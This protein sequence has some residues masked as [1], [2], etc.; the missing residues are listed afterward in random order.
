MA[1]KRG[2]SG[3]PGN[4]NGAHHP[5]RS[6]WRRRALRP[7]DKW[8]VPV[9]ESYRAGFES[10][11][12]DLTEGECRTLEIAIT[13]RG[14]QMLILAEA[15]RSGFTHPVNKT[16][17]LAPGVK[18]LAKFQTVELQALRAI[19]LERRARPVPTLAQYLEQRAI[20]QDDERVA[21]PADGGEDA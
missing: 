21:A 7:A 15:A 5:W 16:W 9:L 17:D 1:G 2:R 18:E 19:G 4:L 3:P 6:F 14:A 12:P 13:A 10:D 11:K 8:I 20:E